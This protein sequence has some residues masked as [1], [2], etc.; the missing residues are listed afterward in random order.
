MKILIVYYSRTGVTKKLAIHL[1]SFLNADLEEIKDQNSRLGL[2]GYL[3]SGKEA[4]LKKII[5]IEKL[6]F[7]PKDYD[8]V[9]VGTPVWAFTISSPV[10]SF[11]EKYKNDFK[12][13]AM[14][15]TQGGEGEQKT[16][17][18]AEKIVGSPAK[19]FLRLLTKQ[20]LRKEFL[21]EIEVFKEKLEK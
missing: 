16:L 7:D 20:V 4:A 1:A 3:N 8:L 9:L 5:P 14:F 17:S 19:A 15:C 11:L 6:I 10:R 18:S 2:L 21:S 13:W 12:A